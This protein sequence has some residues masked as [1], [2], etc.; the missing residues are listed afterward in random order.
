MI[1]LDAKIDSIVRAAAVVLKQLQGVFFV[2]TCKNYS[3]TKLF[4]DA[5]TYSTKKKYEERYLKQD[6]K[7]SLDR[8]PDI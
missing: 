1:F 5:K 7:L 8:V 4:S 2:H 3:Q 6:I